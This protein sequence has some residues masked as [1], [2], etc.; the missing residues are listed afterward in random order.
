VWRAGPSFGSPEVYT[1]RVPASSEAETTAGG[2]RR[3]LLTHR[4]TKAPAPPKGPPG[5]H[6]WISRAWPALAVSRVP[7]K[8][9][10]TDMAPFCLS[11][12]HGDDYQQWTAH[13]TSLNLVYVN[14]KVVPI[15]WFDSRALANAGEGDDPPAGM[16]GKT[17]RTL[18]WLG[19][20]GRDMCIDVTHLQLSHHF[21]RDAGIFA[22]A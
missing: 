9:L 19:P 10:D 14:T 16:G 22:I 11:E 1:L 15:P 5:S 13:R 12:N 20:A 18:G 7:P 21:R 3:A 2:G 17:R 6:P 4:P 8:L